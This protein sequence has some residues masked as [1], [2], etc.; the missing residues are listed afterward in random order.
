MKIYL[1][2]DIEGTCGIVSWDETVLEKEDS[3]IYREQMGKEVAS[4]CIGARSAGAD[5]ILVKD[6]H[7]SARNIDPRILPE[8][9]LLFRGWSRDPLM[10]MSGLDESFGACLFTGYHSGASTGGNP[11]AHTMDTELTYIKVN[12]E[13]ASEFTLNAYACA[14]Y[15][16][17]V[18]FLS[19]DEA[20]CESAKKL[21]PNIVTASVNR[22]YGNGSISVHP[23]LATRMIED[24]VKDALS[25]DISRHLIELPKHFEVEIR[26]TEAYKAFKAS[27]YPGMK[28]VDEHTVSYE[29]DDYY[30]V[31]RMILFI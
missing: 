8:Y 2:A 10:M 27:F 24:G 17:P 28:M 5:E 13:I 4:A 26:Y 18:A 29:T 25:G 1:S 12:G 20:L 9:A 31:L 11:L 3:K 7:H 19:G 30:D 16:V 23:N 14:Y 22:G 21:N 6:A 15:K